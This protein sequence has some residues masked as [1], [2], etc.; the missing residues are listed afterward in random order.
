MKL[1]EKGRTNPVGVFDET[2]HKLNVR[3]DPEHDLRP[4]L[5]YVSMI[6]ET[7]EAV[8]YTR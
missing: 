2:V 1:P 3:C 4:F 5:K 8:K 7:L 6:M